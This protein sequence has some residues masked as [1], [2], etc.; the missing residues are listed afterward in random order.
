MSL[1]ILVFFLGEWCP[2]WQDWSRDQAKE[3]E[4]GL[5][6]ENLVT[7]WLCQYLVSKTTRSLL[8]YTYIYTHEQKEG[9]T[10]L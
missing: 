3:H 6:H 10:H 9:S 4:C 2:G 8:T 7:N 1:D 5:Y